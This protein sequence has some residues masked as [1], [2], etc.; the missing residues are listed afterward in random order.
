MSRERLLYP[1]RFFC[2]G[3]C[4]WEEDARDTSNLARLVQACGE[5]CA[6]GGT[7]RMDTRAVRK[8]SKDLGFPVGSALEGRLR[9]LE[10]TCRG[11]SEGDGDGDG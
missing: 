2:S 1:V 3:R 10:G 5:S 7:L 9:W 6:C 8:D 11:S 4:G